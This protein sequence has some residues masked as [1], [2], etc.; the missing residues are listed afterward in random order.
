LEQ[1]V[2]MVASFQGMAL[3]HQRS[4]Q[5]FPLR[6]MWDQ[7]PEGAGRD[8][9]TSLGGEVRVITVYFQ[10]LLFRTLPSLTNHCAPLPPPR[11]WIPEGAWEAVLVVAVQPCSHL[12]PFHD[13]LLDPLS[14]QI[15]HHP[16]QS[17]HHY[18]C[19]NF[20]HQLHHDHHH[21]YHILE[22]SRSTTASAALWLHC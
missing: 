15:L 8:P 7:N 5:T 13:H 14:F 20:H 16:S 18:L 19:P 6:H 2:E 4:R 17:Y 21:N 9:L 12:Q 10:R 22:R 11:I 3:F 1:Q